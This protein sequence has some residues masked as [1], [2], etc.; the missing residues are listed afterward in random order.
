MLEPWEL[1]VKKENS[2][3]VGRFGKL[4]CLSFNGNKIITTGGG[5]AI[6]TES[7]D[8]Y[9]KL[10]HLSTTAGSHP[11]EIEHDQIGWNDRM[12]NLNAALGL[13]QLEIFKDILERKQ[14]IHKIYKEISQSTLCSFVE[15]S[16]Y[17]KSNYWLNRID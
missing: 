15:H 12:P 8:L 4:G 13:S 5:G 6:F 1:L 17:C 3:H 7:K 10:L 16:Q 11:Y 9:Q 14:K 2:Y